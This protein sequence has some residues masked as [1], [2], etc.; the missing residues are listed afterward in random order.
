[1]N[2][3]IITDIRE[4]RKEAEEVKEIDSFIGS[5]VEYMVGFVKNNPAVLGLAAPQ[6]GV[7]LRIVVLKLQN[8][9]IVPIINPEIK[10]REG[11]NLETEETCLSLPM[12]RVKTNRSKGVVV[13]GYSPENKPLI[14]HLE[15]QDAVVAQHEIDH[16]DGILILDRRVDG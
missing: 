12:V 16:L 6:I 9:K 15:N 4:L 3:A 8:G 13:W 2:K 14:M 7:P 5:I 11:G 10:V 1:M